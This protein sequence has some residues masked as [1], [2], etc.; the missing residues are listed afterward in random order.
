MVMALTRTV[1]GL[2]RADVMVIVQRLEVGK[3]A[4]FFAKK[5]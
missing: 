5:T 1:P 2:K 4:K 3:G